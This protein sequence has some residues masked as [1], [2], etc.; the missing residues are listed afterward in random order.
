MPATYDIT[1][2]PLVDGSLAD[3]EPEELDA[4]AIE[5]EHVLGLRGTAFTGEDAADAK[6]AIVRQAKRTLEWERHQGVTSISKAG[7]SQTFS[8]GN[9]PIDLVARR[10][11]DRLNGSQRNATSYPVGNT[12][13]F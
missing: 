13:T 2:H 10:I 5:A 11:A 12:G 7:Q 8:E 6:I 4:R 1:G 9:A 3:L